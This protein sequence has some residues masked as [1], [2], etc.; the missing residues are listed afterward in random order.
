MP[1]RFSKTKQLKKTLMEE[2]REDGGGEV[3]GQ[4]IDQ[5]CDFLMMV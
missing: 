4:L 2:E 5:L 1:E 3:F